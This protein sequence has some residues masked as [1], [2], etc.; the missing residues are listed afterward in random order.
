MA[1]INPLNAGLMQQH[2]PKAMPFSFIHKTPPFASWKLQQP[3]TAHTDIRIPHMPPQRDGWR[4][5]PSFSQ[6][7][8]QVHNSWGGWGLGG[9]GLVRWI[10][11]DGRDRGPEPG[12]WKW[13]QGGLKDASG[14]SYKFLQECLWCLS[15]QQYKCVVLLFHQ[16]HALLFI[17]D[18]Q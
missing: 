10:W 18:R 8:I 2:Q 17:S 14:I 7:S 1:K 3:P 12:G 11:R 4:A 15:G 9:G 16:T 5:F 6:A 13:G